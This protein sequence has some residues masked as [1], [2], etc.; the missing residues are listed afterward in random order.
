MNGTGWT[1]AAGIALELIAMQF[2]RVG[3]VSGPHAMQSWLERTDTAS[4]VADADAHWPCTR[5]A[6]ERSIPGLRVRWSYRLCGRGDARR[7]IDVRFVNVADSPA[8]LEFAA[9]LR[10]PATCAAGNA[11]V[12][13]RIALESGRSS[14]ALEAFD[15][16][17]SEYRGRLWLCAARPGSVALARPTSSSHGAPL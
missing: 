2:V 9:F 6:P 5:F 1:L 8:A 16:A 15:V 12:T 7:R 14:G 10:R 11:A 13:G 4:M 17:F 3:P